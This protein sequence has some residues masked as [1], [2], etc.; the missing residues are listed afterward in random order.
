[1]D[2]GICI[3]I[4]GN[5]TGWFLILPALVGGYVADRYPA[6]ADPFSGVVLMSGQLLMFSVHWIIKVPELAK[7]LMYGGLAGL[8]FGNGF[9]SPIFHHRSQL[10]ERATNG[11][12]WPILIFGVKCGC[13]YGSALVR[14]SRAIRV[15]LPISGGIGWPLPSWWI[16]PYTLCNTENKY[17]IGP[18]EMQSRG[19]RP[20]KVIKAKDT[21][22][23]LQS[24]INP[25]RLLAVLGAVAVGLLQ[26]SCYI[27]TMTDWGRDIYSLYCRCRLT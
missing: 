3:A 7:W 22:E 8:I 19:S 24:K 2:K 13:I 1:M 4:Y 26:W 5:Y 9:S 17:P 6:C 25:N 18:T 27:S 21:A 10:Y 14:L 20:H 12:I 23:G 15:F 11:S 16:K